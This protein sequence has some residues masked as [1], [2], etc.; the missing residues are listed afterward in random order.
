MAQLPEPIYVN[1]ETLF[2]KTVRSLAKEKTIA[3]DTESNSLYAYR[4]QVCL[5]QFSTPSTDYLV[6]PLAVKDISSLAP[7]FADAGIEKVFHAAEYDLLCLKRDFNFTFDNLFDTMVAARI[8]GIEKVGLGNML[9]DRF[10]VQL[11]KK[12]QKANWGKRPLPRRMLSY[13]RMD[14]HFLIELRAKLAVMLEEKQR[15]PIARE[16]FKRLTQ[17]N[18]NPPGPIDIDI[19]RI[20]GA[21]DLSPT[22][23]A[24]LQELA[25]FRDTK[26]QDYNRPPFKVIGDKALMEIAI[27]APKS[28]HELQSLPHLP[29]KF[30][31][32]HGSE[33]L[34]AVQL[35]RESKGLK[36]PSRHYHQNGY[37]ERMEALREWRKSRAMQIGVESDV[38]LPRDVMIAIAT[39][40][41]SSIKELASLMGSTPWRLKEYGVQIQQT[42]AKL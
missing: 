3:V 27:F 42:L 35:G 26:A 11:E 9:A 32:R 38:V 31:K 24:V 23:A 41:P 25:L 19:W 34:R 40:N 29:E 22:Q 12:F 2:T 5:I 13:A 37:M 1:D 8:C 30:I 6:D 21:R 17:V 7:I 15:W 10:G 39:D 36:P 28:M 20:N 18:G 33:L 16:D 14:T 4:E